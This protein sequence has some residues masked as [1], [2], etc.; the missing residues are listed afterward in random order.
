MSPV[1]NLPRER[2]DRGSRE[3]DRDR[4]SRNR[5]RVDRDKVDRDRERIDRER[6]R[7]ER[8]GRDSVSG[9][10]TP[11][12]DSN[13]G[14]SANQPRGTTTLAGIFAPSQKKRCRDFDG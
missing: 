1:P 6:E 3:R 13:P 2:L 8:R 9:T 14:D 10:A 4:Q 7:D 5:D 12:Q 11:T